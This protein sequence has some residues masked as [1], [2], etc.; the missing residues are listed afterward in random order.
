MFKAS[1]WLNLNYNDKNK[2][3]NMMG[4][5]ISV[6]A[7]RSRGFV[8]IM[9][10]VEKETSAHSLSASLLLLQGNVILSSTESQVKGRKCVPSISMHQI[11]L[12]YL[13]KRHFTAKLKTPNFSWLGFAC[14]IT[15][16]IHVKI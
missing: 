2:G 6:C 16:L 8:F 11:M 1:A 5:S 15:Y 10:R 4:E 9:I 3:Y 7:P 13:F 14:L 12:I